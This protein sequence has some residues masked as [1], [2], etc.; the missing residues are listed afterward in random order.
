MT[1]VKG[2]IYDVI[3]DLRPDSPTYGRWIGVD[4]SDNNCRQM[5]VPPGCAHGYYAYENETMVFYVQ[6]KPNIKLQNLS[7]KS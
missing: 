1:C 4:L 2:R 6:V 7:L 5:F 3:A